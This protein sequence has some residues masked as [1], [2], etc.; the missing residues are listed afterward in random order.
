MKKPTLS[1]I[2]QEACKITASE[3][4]FLENHY[5]AIPQDKGDIENVIRSKLAEAGEGTLIVFMIEKFTPET[6]SSSKPVGTVELVAIVNENAPL[7]RARAAWAA[8]F[9]AAEYLAVHLNLKQVF[10][11]T[12]HSPSIQFRPVAGL[13]TYHVTFKMQH[14]LQGL[15]GK[16]NK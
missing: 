12:L 9:T 10:E 4:W 5:E 1:A 15:P 13:I 3:P 6:S 8:A 14:A 16:E 2:L 11:C 7:N